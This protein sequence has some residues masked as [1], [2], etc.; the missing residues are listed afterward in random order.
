[1]TIEVKFI[2]DDHCGRL[3]RWLRFIGY[4]CAYERDIDDN[5][6]LKRAT[7]EDRIILTRDSKIPERA[8]ARTVIVVDSPVPLVQLRQVIG[9][10][11]LTLG[12]DRIGTRC[13]V[14]NGMA[15]T[16]ALEDI[17]ERVPPYVRQTQTSFRECA[18]CR[19]IYWHGTHV[20]NMIAK[21]S[22]AGLLV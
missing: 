12:P 8:M 4:D 13:S 20:K 3:A 5:T 19:R 2:C 21:L 14:C 10:L 17:A 6:L 11:N 22:D 9:D 7:G 1:M 18:T 16:V 15:D